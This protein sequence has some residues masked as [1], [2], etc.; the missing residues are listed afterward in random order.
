[1]ELL[2]CPC[3]PPLL[4]LLQGMGSGWNPVL[5]DPGAELTP[6]TSR[7]RRTAVSAAQKRFGSPAPVS[8]PAM[9]PLE[10]C[11]QH[12]ALLFGNSNGNFNVFSGSWYV[13]KDGEG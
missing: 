9:V 10:L 3:L 7:R 4:L 11:S 5:G 12:T 1:M 2:L 8:S 6:K 13:P